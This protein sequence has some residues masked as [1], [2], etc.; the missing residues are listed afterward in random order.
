MVLTRRIMFRNI[1][2]SFSGIC[3]M[4]RRIWPVFGSGT[5]NVSL[6]WQLSSTIPDHGNKCKI[7]ETFAQ[8]YLL[9]QQEQIFLGGKIEQILFE[10]EICCLPFLVRCNIFQKFLYVLIVQAHGSVILFEIFDSLMVRHDI[11]M[12]ADHVLHVGP[13]LH[14]HFGK[15]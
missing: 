2:S 14:D 15:L 12:A 4:S 8:N 9:V 7:L 13:C 6:N 3:E 5:R 10:K 1:S 11:A